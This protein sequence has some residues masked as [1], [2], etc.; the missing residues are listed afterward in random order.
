MTRREKRDTRVCMCFFTRLDD[1]ESGLFLSFIT[2][3]F[4]PRT[5]THSSDNTYTAV[6]IVHRWENSLI[7]V[8]IYQLVVV[9]SL[10]DS[11]KFQRSKIDLVI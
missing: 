8:V 7:Q 10:R 2:I 3:T 1:V 6:N 11:R 9:N 4:S 5:V